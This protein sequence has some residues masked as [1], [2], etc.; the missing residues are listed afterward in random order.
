[1]QTVTPKELEVLKEVKYYQCDFGWSEYTSDKAKCKSVAGTLSSLE[2]KGLI[3]DGNNLFTDEDFKG[4]SIDGEKYKMW[5]LSWEAT[6][7]V[8]VPEEW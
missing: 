3:Y 7:I 1:M 2:K 5:L 8:G 6:E 4:M